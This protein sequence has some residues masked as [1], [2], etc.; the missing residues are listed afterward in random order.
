MNFLQTDASMF[1]SFGGGGGGV[2]TFSSH[3]Y[4]QVLPGL[5]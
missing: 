5:P 4:M 1:F 2:I 3:M